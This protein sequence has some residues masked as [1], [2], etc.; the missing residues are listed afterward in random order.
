MSNA[1]YFNFL[2]I[3]FHRLKLDDTNVAKGMW[4]NSYSICYSPIRS[5]IQKNSNP[6]TCLPNGGVLN[7]KEFIPN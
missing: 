2:L 3:L 6:A 7:L 5:L 1:H 4:D